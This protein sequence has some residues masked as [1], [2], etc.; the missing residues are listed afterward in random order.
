[1]VWESKVRAG[2]TTVCLLDVAVNMIWL[3]PGFCGEALRHWSVLR[4]PAT[5][6]TMKQPSWFLASF[7]SPYWLM[8]AC[9]L[10]LF[11]YSCWSAPHICLFSITKYL[12]NVCRVC[13]CS[14][15]FS[16]LLSC[17]F[18]PSPPPVASQPSA[19]WVPH[20]RPDLLVISSSYKGA[21]FMA[22]LFSKTPGDSLFCNRCNINKL[23]WSSNKSSIR[24]QRQIFALS[25]FSQL[26]CFIAVEKRSM[27]MK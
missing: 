5:V 6:G 27:S 22:L 15:H 13:P 10:S 14:S 12:F 19:R 3:V 23:D 18:T 20:M 4:I 16:T 9:L 25:L 8:A 21:L 24:A 2:G 7:T 11:L 1:M 17:P 26:W